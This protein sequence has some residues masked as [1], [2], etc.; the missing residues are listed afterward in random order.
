MHNIYCTCAK[1]NIAQCYHIILQY[2]KISTLLSKHTAQLDLSFQLFIFTY[3]TTSRPLTG[4]HRKPCLSHL[5]LNTPFKSTGKIDRS[6][7]I[8][9][10]RLLYSAF[11]FADRARAKRHSNVVYAASNHV[12]SPEM[13]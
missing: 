7:T 13:L 12:L 3:R 4:N 5:C 6:G 10:Q 8:C 9:T 1:H 2:C 11:I